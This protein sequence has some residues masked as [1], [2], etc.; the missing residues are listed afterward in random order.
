MSP[1]SGRD[2]DWD[3]CFNAR[4]LGGL[5][6]ADGRT[7]RWG[8]LVRSDS[9]DGLTASGWASLRAHRV[10]TVVDLRNGDERDEATG[11]PPDVTT[12]HVP[13]DDAADLGFW[14]HVRAN[15]LDGTPLYY[16]LFL[17]RKPER[18][19]AAVVAVARARPAGV[20]V[21]CVGGRDR[22]G[23]VTLLLLALVG[24]RPE[25]IAADYERS[26]ERLP[27]RW[28]ARGEEDQRREI[29]EILERRRT[30]ARSLIVE[31]VT[32]L[33]VPAY[34][35]AAGLGDDDVAAL[36]ARLLAPS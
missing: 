17:E 33:D 10:R 5:L 13:L 7:T 32:S 8:A 31:L 29:G 35:R 2:L 23:L 11:S 15:E 3:G 19:A 16:R 14:D 25:D 21:H 27:A 34:L 6:T 1:K 20:L 4:D 30:S 24:V 12:V 9:V 26:N 28:G 36:R 22:T 18:V